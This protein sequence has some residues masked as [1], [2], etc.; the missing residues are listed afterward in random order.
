METET[1]TSSVRHVRTDLL[2]DTMR[3]VL[4]TAGSNGQL[5]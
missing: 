3:R 5:M 2:R 1:V 4:L